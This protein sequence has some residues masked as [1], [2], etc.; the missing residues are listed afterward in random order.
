[1]CCS[2][3]R[4][5]VDHKEPDLALIPHIQKPVLWAV[6]EH[7]QDST[8]GPQ[9]KGHVD[10]LSLKQV[11]RKSHSAVIVVG[12][13]QDSAGNEGVAGFG[14]RIG[15]VYER[16]DGEGLLIQLGHHDALVSARS[17]DQPQAVLICCQLEVSL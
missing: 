8:S 5:E 10:S 14:A 15:G 4:N 17:K 12:D 7:C 9:V 16:C 6:G 1:M 3:I 2:L 11:K 13:V